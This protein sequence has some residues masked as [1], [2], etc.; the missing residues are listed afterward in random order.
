MTDDNSFIIRSYIVFVTKILH[1]VIYKYIS[2]KRFT[3]FLRTMQ[4]LQYKRHYDYN[5]CCVS[6]RTYKY[7]ASH[8]RP[9][10]EASWIEV[11]VLNRKLVAL[12]NRGSLATVGATTTF[13]NTTGN[14]K[15]NYI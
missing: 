13:S 14:H 11:G 12:V 8:E 5:V 9:Y 6:L 15:D 4:L 1:I 7:M 10:I 3:Y 2:M